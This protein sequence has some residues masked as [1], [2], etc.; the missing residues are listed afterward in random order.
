MMEKS[1]VNHE[2]HT[3]HE[4]AI[5]NT[6]VLHAPPALVYQAW[7]DPQYLAKWWGPSGFTNTFQVFEFK[8]GGQWEFV[9]H[10]PDG[11]D[12]FNQSEFVETAQERIVLRHLCE[13][14]FQLTITLEDVE[15]KTRLT[16]QQLFED[17]ATVEAVKGFA[18]SANEQNL[19]RLEACLQEMSC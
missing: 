2:P 8:P 18:G 9:M 11:V 3:E 4:H 1:P 7:S 14:H 12:Y 13:P 16:W 5:V 10:G 6:R 17:A 19:D 15:G